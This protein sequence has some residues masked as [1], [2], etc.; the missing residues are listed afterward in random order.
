MIFNFAK[1]EFAIDNKVLK[2]KSLVANNYKIG[3]TAK[4]FYNLKDNSFLT[5]RVR[6]VASKESVLEIDV[7]SRAENVCDAD[8]ILYYALFFEPS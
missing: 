3:I 8:H 1:A 6:M 5:H 4:G 7:S 2:I